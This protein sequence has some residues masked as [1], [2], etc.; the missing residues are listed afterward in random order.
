M[1]DI[2]DHSILDK[3]PN[4]I[5]IIAGKNLDRYLYTNAA[6]E[7]LTGYTGEE[8]LKIHPLDVV[9]PDMRE[10]TIRRS[11]QRFKGLNPVQRYDLK[12]ITKQS[13]EIWTDFS[14]SLIEYHGQKALL[15]AAIDRTEEKLYQQK[16]ADSEKRYRG[17]LDSMLEGCQIIDRNWRYIYLNDMVISHS[18]RPR[19]E[20]LGKT[21]MEAY[22]GIENTDL[23]EK[24]RRCREESVPLRFL[25]RFAY[26][27]G[28][29]RWFELNVQPVPEGIFILSI[30]RTASVEADEIHKR[31]R[32]SE[33]LL[34]RIFNSSAVG[35]NLFGVT[36]GKSVMV[37]ETYSRITGYPREEILNH[38]AMELNLFPDPESRAAWMNEL[39]IRGKIT[40]E[41]TKIR[42]KSGEIRTV[43][44][45][46]EMI[47][48]NDEIMTLVIMTDI[49]EERRARQRQRE[50]E[51]RFHTVFDQSAV[52]VVQSLGSGRLVDVNDRF[53]DILGYGKEELLSKTLPEITYGEDRDLETPFIARI[54]AGEIDSFELEKRFVS[55]QGKLVWTRIYSNVVRSEEGDPLYAVA[56][57]VDISQQ[58][59]NE[60]KH[61][62]LESQLAQAQKMEAVGRLA[63]GVAHDFNNILTII[64]GFSELLLAGDIPGEIRESVEQIL[65]AGEKAARLTTQLLAFSRKQIIK[66]MVLDIN[67]VVREQ[68]K[69]LSRILGEDIEIALSLNGD[70][71][72]VKMDQ[73]QMDQIIMNIVINARD[74]MER[75]GRL[76]LETGISHF[77]REDALFHG[78]TAAGHYGMLAISDNGTGMSRET[79]EQIFEPFFTTKGVEQ[80][81]G[82]GLAM[83]FGIVKQ[84]KGFIYVYS[85]LDEG[86]TFKIFLPLADTQDRE[87]HQ[88]NQLKADQLKGTETILVVEDDKGV[89][90]TAENALAA[91]GY[92]VILADNGEE[93]LEAFREHRERIALVLT[94]VIMPRLGGR[95]L[96]ARLKRDKPDLKVIYFSGYTGDSITHQ[97]VLDGDIDFIQKPFS[98]VELVRKIREVLNRRGADYKT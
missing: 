12:L 39:K 90:K 18:R 68:M 29:V 28:E 89:Q 51:L 98:P 25:N 66:P 10:Q 19:E 72:P 47:R 1:H 83:V 58:L 44:A 61:R 82:L 74:A 41:E 36:D 81:T 54:T 13:K 52:G 55:K 26:D 92:K 27:D 64:N 37:N 56:V 67:R 11:Q 78:G 31:Q 95:E 85:E 22:P 38:S 86:T 32:E 8:A 62:D 30:D 87:E 5:S 94:D 76:I 88:L 23:F 93:G 6:W 71:V 77:D 2:I 97:G 4:A 63:G 14:V 35:F 69:L 42:T 80:G 9:H 24:L 3:L 40:N 34:S 59:E 57:V 45:T 49:T 53:C 70:A 91:Y 60:K 43:A 75:G 65:K 79:R 46:L 50:S 16:L 21:M 20:L 15:T 96:V 33:E 48:I 7:R 73:G 17:T 84:N